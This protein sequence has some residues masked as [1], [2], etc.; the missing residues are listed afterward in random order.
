MPEIQKPEKNKSEDHSRHQNKFFY[1]HENISEYYNRLLRTSLI[2]LTEWI[3]EYKD[4][5]EP[6]QVIYKPAINQVKDPL[7]FFSRKIL[8]NFQKNYPVEHL[9]TVASAEKKYV[10]YIQQCTNYKHNNS[11]SLEITSIVLISS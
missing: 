6:V 11:L 7:T 4:L 9:W 8:Q 5:L 3:L 2:T 1:R 10:S